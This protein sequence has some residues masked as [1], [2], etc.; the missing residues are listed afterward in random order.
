MNVNGNL[1][2]LIQ[3]SNGYSSNTLFLSYSKP[4]NATNVV[5]KNSICELPKELLTEISSY[6]KPDTQNVFRLTSKK[7]NE[8]ILNNAKRAE[9]DLIR[10]SNLLGNVDLDNLAKKISDSNDLQ[11][12][13]YS[14]HKL[15]ESVVNTFTTLKKNE[16]DLLEKSAIDKK[17]PE[18][19]KSIMELGEITT[20]LNEIINAWPDTI[21]KFYV[22]QS[23]IKAL[24]KNG[25]GNIDKSIAA[26]KKIL[27]R[28]YG[29][30]IVA[31]IIEALVKKGHLKRGLNITKAMIHV[32]NQSRT[33][34]K[35]ALAYV[36]EGD[37]EK[38]LEVEKRI[39]K[40]NQESL[41]IY[42]DTL[43]LACQEVIFSAT[44]LGFAKKGDC[45]NAVLM[46]IYIPSDK[47]RI[48]VIDRI[49]E[50]S[51]MTPE[52]LCNYQPRQDKHLIFATYGFGLFLP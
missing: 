5:S 30:D 46:T 18:F 23:T 44:S 36:N 24:L 14:A 50:I 12:I 25:N 32:S 29:A 6:L 15:K 16:I 34:V 52:E 19:F 7:F 47:K 1:F 27:D 9:I 42:G 51:K 37:I 38:A 4:N 21:D 10:F 49:N 17:L 40:N 33:Y 8:I 28:Y 20:R 41:F 43:N 13:L 35:I 31:K 45:A 11:E 48:K 39:N 3:E 22:I 26:S 2:K